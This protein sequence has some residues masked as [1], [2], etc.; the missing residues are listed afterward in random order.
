M[1]DIASL[2]AAVMSTVAAGMAMY[3]WWHDRIERKELERKNR[4]QEY[5]K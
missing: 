2:V 4:Q 1:G 3:E 5:D